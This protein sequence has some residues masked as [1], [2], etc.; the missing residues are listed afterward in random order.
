MLGANVAPPRLLLLTLSSK[1]SK[2]SAINS[3]IQR[4][5]AIP[6]P[7]KAYYDSDRAQGSILAFAFGAFSNA[8]LEGR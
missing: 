7:V 1:F 5:A 4:F 2:T 3:L 6:T 8:S